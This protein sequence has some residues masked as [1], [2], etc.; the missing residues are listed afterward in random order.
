MYLRF[1][2]PQPAYRNWATGVR[3]ASRNA[4]SG[5][6]G[7]AY[8]V[9]RSHETPH[10]LAK[11]L[12][13]ELRWF[14]DNL[15]VPPR[16][17]VITRRSSRKYIGLCWFRPEA[18]EALRHAYAMASLLSE[19]GVPVQRVKSSMPGHFLYRDAQQVVAEP[20][21]AAVWH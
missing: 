6:F 3:R 5:F 17:G 14:G 15:A 13:E 18:N 7:P 16:F 11:A 21:Q 12:D 20:M 19:A 1:I 4:A 2:T 8:T 9:A 10:W